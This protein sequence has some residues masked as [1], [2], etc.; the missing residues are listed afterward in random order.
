M[1]FIATA[2]V[3]V[4]ELL[5]RIKASDWEGVAVILAACLIGALAGVFGVEGL[6]VAD[7]ILAGLTAVGIHQVARQVG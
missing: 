1:L 6:N 3:A 7:G 4:T 5:K 2:I